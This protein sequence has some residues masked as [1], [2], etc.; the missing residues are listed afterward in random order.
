[1]ICLLLSRRC[2]VVTLL[3][4]CCC[5]VVFL[6]LPRHCSVVVSSLSCCC[7][8]VFLLLSRR[9]PVVVSS[10]SCRCLVV[11]LFLPF[12]FCRCLVV[13]SRYP[14]VTLLFIFVVV[15]LLS[16]LLLSTHTSMLVWRCPSILRSDG[17]PMTPACTW[18]NRQ[19]EDP[20]SGKLE[21][22]HPSRTSV[23]YDQGF[24]VSSQACMSTLHHYISELLLPQHLKL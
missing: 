6:L 8:V 10:L 16:V 11:V 2:P 1:M 21:S 14:V 20:S 24:L 9:C 12:L 18:W 13:S 17:H 3:L 23:K 5:L 19:E 22:T 15:F 4:S 7:L